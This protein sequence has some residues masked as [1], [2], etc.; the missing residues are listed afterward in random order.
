MTKK[1]FREAMSA[2]HNHGAATTV[3]GREWDRGASRFI[4]ETFSTADVPPVER[5]SRHE[6]IFADGFKSAA[7]LFGELNGKSDDFIRDRIDS[8][9][10][11]G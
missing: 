6:G 9:W 5:T 7:K 11:G 3:K 8:A 1:Q 10:N 2:V 4:R